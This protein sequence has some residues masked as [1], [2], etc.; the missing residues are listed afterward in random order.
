MNT[1]TI[2]EAALIL[3]PRLVG[4]DFDGSLDEGLD[5][6]VTYAEE[7]AQHYGKDAQI[8]LRSILVN[9]QADRVAEIAAAAL[10]RLAKRQTDEDRDRAAEDLARRVRER[11][12]GAALDF[13]TDDLG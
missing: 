4:D 2:R 1:D 9:S 13:A 8:T 3:D 11:S 5:A 12:I 6:I 10:L 7:A